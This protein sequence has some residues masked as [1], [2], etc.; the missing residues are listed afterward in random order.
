MRTSATPKEDP[1]L[2]EVRN[3]YVVIPDGWLSPSAGP[4]PGDDA[5]RGGAASPPPS[6]RVNR[7][8]SGPGGDRVPVKRKRRFSTARGGRSTDRSAVAL[9]CATA[10]P[11]IPVTDLYEKHVSAMGGRLCQ[12]TRE[13]SI[14]YGRLADNGVAAV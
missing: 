7:S 11:T 4:G 1:A 9:A 3:D 2:A 12:V 14:L 8:T 13:D 5:D 6:G 10:P